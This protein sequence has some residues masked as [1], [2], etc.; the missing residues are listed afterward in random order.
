MVAGLTHPALTTEAPCWEMSRWSTTVTWAPRSPRRWAIASP[1]TPPP[2]TTT[3][4]GVGTSEHLSRIHD[5]QGGEHPSD[6]PLDLE[7]VLT[8]LRRK[9]LAFEDPHA[10][11]ARERAAEPQRRSEQVFGRRPDLLGDSA[12]GRIDGKEEVGMQIAVRGMCN[13][14]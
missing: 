5:P 10:V 12:V 2:M 1:T 14:R 7:L 9:P 8:Q 11:L 6:T 3:R 4:A 13:R